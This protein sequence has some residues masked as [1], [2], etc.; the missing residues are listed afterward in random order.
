MLTVVLIGSFPA[1][2]AGKSKR[3]LDQETAATLAEMSPEEVKALDKQLAE[4]LSHYYNEEF[5]RALP[6]LKEISDKVETLD[7]MFWIGN[8]AMKTGEYELSIEKFRKMLDIDP[9]LQRVRLE[10]ADVLYNTG[11][12]Q[13]ARRELEIVKASSPPAAVQR[14]IDQRLG[15]IAKRGKKVQWGFNMSTGYQY[16]GNVTSGPEASEIAIATGTLTLDKDSQEADGYNWLV[17]MNGSVRYDIGDLKGL[18]W[19]GRVNVYS[20]Y[21]ASDYSDY[22]YLATDVST[23]PMWVMNRAILRIPAGFRN[24]RYGNEHLSD[25]IHI[26]PKVEVFI[27]KTLGLQAG[28]THAWETYAGD[29]YSGNDNVST[30]I[31]VGPNLYLSNRRHMLSAAFS[32]EDREADIDSLSYNTEAVELSY[33]TRLPTKTDIFLKCKT[34]ER[35]Y[36]GIPPL[37][38]MERADRRN[39]LTAAISQQIMKRYYLSLSYVYMENDSNAE[40]Y[41]FAKNIFAL[42]VGVAF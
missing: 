22:N 17:K 6:L 5:Q 40:L 11:R 16:D 26:D 38:N 35:K 21:S 7:L 3:A 10:L 24:T 18:M 39:T 34:A 42:D 4:A 27:N 33:Y 13:E 28:Y 19:N 15:M 2:A 36:E 12:L 41:S 25:T 30:K 29:K 23:G 32:Y 14:K 8:S 1:T 9:S 37:Y 20:S 31:S